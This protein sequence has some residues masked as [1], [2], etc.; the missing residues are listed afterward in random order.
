MTQMDCIALPSPSVLILSYYLFYIHLGTNNKKA[1]R[2]EGLDQEC[3]F[4]FFRAWL[5][6][7]PCSACL[8]LTLCTYVSLACYIYVFVTHSFSQVPSRPEEL[9]IK[10]LD[11]PVD[12][13][14]TLH[15]RIC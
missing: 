11:V 15:E 12:K 3:C 1:P 13:T 10:G 14:V 4:D 9:R 7:L 8:Q 6:G 5:P 2:Q